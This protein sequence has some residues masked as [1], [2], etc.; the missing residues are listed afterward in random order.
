MILL[1]ET[2]EKDKEVLY[3]FLDKHDQYF[4]DNED[5]GDKLI[6]YIKHNP[7]KF[8]FAGSYETDEG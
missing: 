5:F 7:E 6:E 4:Y 2:E 3:D 1:S 8:V